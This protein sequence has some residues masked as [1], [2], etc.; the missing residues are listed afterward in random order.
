MKF[1]LQTEMVTILY[2]LPRTSG[3]TKAKT[4]LET[5]CVSD[6]FELHVTILA[7]IGDSPTSRR[8]NQNS[9]KKDYRKTHWC[10]N[11]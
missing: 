1:S 2:F 10:E 7:T 8:K 3:N 6:K 9:D 5:E 11:P 4:M